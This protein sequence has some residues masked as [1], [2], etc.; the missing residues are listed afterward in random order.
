MPELNDIGVSHDR[1]VEKAAN[2][3]K[4]QKN[5]R[6]VLEEFT[7]GTR[8]GEIPD[9][10][11]WKNRLSYLVECKTSRSDFFRDKKKNFRKFNPNNEYW[12][13]YG[14]GIYRYYFVPDGLIEPDE[15]PDNWGLVYL[16]GRS[17]KEI[18]TCDHALRDNPHVINRDNP[19][20]YNEPTE[21]SLK[22]EI[23]MLVSALGRTLE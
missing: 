22:N 5:C 6:V 10:I 1:L 21:D 4:Y 15:V 2:F 3:L 17:Y 16:E 18:I 23:A 9:V 19:V 13:R 12:N 11:G 7:A 8:G 20:R 14:M